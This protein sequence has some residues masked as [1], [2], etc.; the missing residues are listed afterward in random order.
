MNDDND[1][2]LAE[3]MDRF[4]QDLDTNITLPEVIDISSSVDDNS[5]FDVELFTRELDGLSKREELDT[6]DDV[7]LS[8]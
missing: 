2:V 3:A 7:I 8:E 1:T 5:D 6:S 4:E